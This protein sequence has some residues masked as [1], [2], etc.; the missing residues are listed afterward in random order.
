MPCANCASG[1]DRRAFLEQVIAIL[2]VGGLAAC[3]SD[4]GTTPS[5]TTFTVSLSSYPALASVGGLALVDNGSRS[6]E[7]IAVS[8]IDAS[9]FLALSLICP[10]RGTTVE[11]VGGSFYCPG[12]GATFAANGN[13]T[14]GQQTSNLGRYAVTYDAGAGTLKI[15]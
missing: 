13:W 7:P 10:H 11:I 2:G 14:G 4:L 1:V 5:I 6:G 12:H 3:A 9:T 8:R 15:G